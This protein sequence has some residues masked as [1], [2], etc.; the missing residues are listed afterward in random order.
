MISELNIPGRLVQI[1]YDTC[2]M[3]P[4]IPIDET[5]EITLREMEKDENLKERTNW[6]PYHIVEL[7]KICIET[8][9]QRNSYFY[10]GLDTTGGILTGQTFYKRC[11]HNTKKAEKN[12]W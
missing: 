5:L 11:I 4:S 1:S 6:K 9:F 7:C 10:C 12:F 3:Y 2:N 8:R